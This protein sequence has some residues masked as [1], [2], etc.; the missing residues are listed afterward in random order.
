[1]NAA[2]PKPADDMHIS[3][4]EFDRLM[5][6]AL[7]VAPQDAPKPAPRAKRATGAKAKKKPA[8]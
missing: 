8:K 6:K 5:R 2:Q 1:M 7:Q 4:A 3:G